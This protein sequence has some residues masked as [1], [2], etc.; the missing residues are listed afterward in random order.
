MTKPGEVLSYT[1][2]GAAAATGLSRTTLYRLMEDGTL[3]YM[4]VRGCRLIEAGELRALL[5]R[6]AQ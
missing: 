4:K 1:V 5:A 3:P 2:M 6:S